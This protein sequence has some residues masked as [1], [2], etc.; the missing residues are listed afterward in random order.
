[1]NKRI[2]SKT[3]TFKYEE[4]KHKTLKNYIYNH[5]L[6]LFFTPVIY[7][8][9]GFHPCNI[10]C[11]IYTLV[12]FSVWFAPKNHIETV[13]KVAGIHREGYYITHT[14]KIERVIKN[15][16]RV[17]EKKI[18]QPLIINNYINI[19]NFIIFIPSFLCF[20]CKSF[21]ICHLASSPSPGFSF[22]FYDMFFCVLFLIFF[23]WWYSFYYV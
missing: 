18:I 9:F 16:T 23:Y 19:E 15:K 17:Q 13:P 3:K 14:Q 22:S 5:G 1:M 2:S 6:L 11:L 7:V 20:S 10:F 4:Y 12:K 21:T 8:I